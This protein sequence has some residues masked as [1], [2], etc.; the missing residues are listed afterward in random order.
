MSKVDSGNFLTWKNRFASLSVYDYESNDTSD[1]CFSS[2]SDNESFTETL[3]NSISDCSPDP[4]SFSPSPT[5]PPI[6]LFPRTEPYLVRSIR[7][8]RSIEINIGISTLDTHKK[9]N[10]NGLLDCGASGLFIDTKFVEENKLTTRQLPRPV[11]VFNVDGTP[12]EAGYIKEVV[13][14]Q[15]SYKG[16]RERAILH[17][18]N[19]GSSKI[20]LGLPWLRQHNPSIDWTTGDVKMDRC[21]KS[22]GHDIKAARK[23]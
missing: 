10:E 4:S 12:N 21:P 19:L 6:P 18:T 3:I 20:I 7:N 14:L 22:C 11:P 8:N 17:V 16:H 15:V 1:L 9:F 13:E 23:T 5:P 2:N